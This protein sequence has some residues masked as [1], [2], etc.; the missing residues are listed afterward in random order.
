MPYIPENLDLEQILKNND[1]TEFLEPE[2]YDNLLYLIHLTYEQRILYKC[3]QP[4]VPLKAAYLRKF[5]RDYKIYKDLLIQLKIIDCDLHYILGKKS[6]GYKLCINYELKKAKLVN[7][8]SNKLVKI[9]KKWT[10]NRLPKTNVHKY[11]FEKLKLE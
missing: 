1:K 11:L 8:K 6:Y 5:I 7:F 4:Y 9:I 3:K 2:K 10:N